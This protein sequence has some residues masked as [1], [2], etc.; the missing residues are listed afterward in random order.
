MN[1]IVHIE[2]YLF[3]FF[4]YAF[5]GWIYETVYKLIGNKKFMNSG[6]LFGPYVPIYGFGAILIISMETYLSPFVP[7]FLRVL[8]YT[9]IATVLEYYT[10]LLCEYSFGIKLWTYK[11]NKFNLHGRVCFRYS[12]YWMLLIIG[13]LLL[14]QPSI[15]TIS[16]QIPFS[17][18]L[19]INRLL[20]VIFLIDFALALKNLKLIITFFNT[21]NTQYLTITRDKFQKSVHSFNRLLRSFP[22][23]MTYLKTNIKINILKDFSNNISE[24]L[25]KGLLKEAGGAIVFENGN[26]S[27]NEFNKII[28][29]I[30]K[31]EKF[32]QLKDFRHHN[33]TIFDHAKSVAYITYRYCRNKKVDKISATRGALLHDFFLYDWRTG[34]DKRGNHNKGHIYL[35]PRM[36]LEN[37]EKE[38]NLNDIE[39]DIILNHMWPL[40]PSMPKYKETFIVSFIDKYIS[41]KEFIEVIATKA[42][43]SSTVKKR[44]KM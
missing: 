10:G 20:L 3:Y 30:I 7:F 15:K 9:A 34:L 1:N 39:R 31:N 32:L 12:I 6:F 17:I 16:H 23:L 14:F 42:K 13:N 11:N 37:S 27:E 2:I 43:P 35:H 4:I 25:R 40:S 24:V 28:E 38:F 29:D 18:I 5:L 8:I 44:L 41:S 19:N 21:V 36:A 26:G 22:N 33:S